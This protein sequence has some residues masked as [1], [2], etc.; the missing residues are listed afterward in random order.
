M[1]NNDA[2]LCLAPAKALGVVVRNLAVRHGPIYA[3]GEWTATYDPVLLGLGEGE[4]D[5]LNDDRIGRMLHRLFDADRASL[6]TGVVLGMVA[7]FGIDC[8]QLHNDSTSVTLSGTDYPGGGSE[9]SNK[10]I[11]KPAFG[12]NKDFRPDLLQL[13]WVLT[14]SADGAVP[15]AYRVEA[16]NTEDSTTHVATWDGLC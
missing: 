15:I 7:T 14:I 8:A 9:R 13:V 5:A 1:P 11:A 12:H 2:G 4:V 10:T 6:L 16:G 3:M